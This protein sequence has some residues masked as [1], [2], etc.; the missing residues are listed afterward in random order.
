MIGW[1]NG[2]TPV[3][4]GRKYKVPLE[5]MSEMR[6]N[7]TKNLYTTQLQSRYQSFYWLINIL[8]HGK[9]EFITPEGD[10]V[11]LDLDRSRFSVATPPESPTINFTWCYT[12]YFDEW[13]YH[14]FTSISNQPSDKR[15]SALMQESLD[16]EDVFRGLYT[17]KL[18]EVLDTRVSQ[19]LNCAKRCID[20]Y[21]KDKV[22]LNEKRTMSDK[23]I[24][25]WFVFNSEYKNQNGKQGPS[26]L[27]NDQ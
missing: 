19:Y 15:F 5:E 16:S 24:V 18:G 27:K 9:D 3:R 22:L 23:E 14:T 6:Q 26:W 12:C 20:E 1:W 10:L 4:T 17:E 7:L 25:N 11:S 13:T 8:R 21:G 2:L